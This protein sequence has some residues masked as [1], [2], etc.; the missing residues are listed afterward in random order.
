MPERPWCQ[1]NRYKEGAYPVLAEMNVMNLKG[2]LTPLQ[3]AFFA[4]HRV[5][6]MKSADFFYNGRL[7]GPVDFAHVVVA[8]LAGHRNRVEAAQAASH[9]LARRMGGLGGDID[10]WMRHGLGTGAM[11]ETGGGAANDN[12]SD[13]AAAARL[14]RFRVVL[15]NTT[16][17]GNIG[18]VARAMKNMCLDSLWLVAPKH[19]PSADATARA[20]GAD[21]LLERARVCADLDQALA[22]A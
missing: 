16:H 13:G 3:A 20:S 15:I 5:V 4:E 1:F 12:R 21:G 19:F 18:A 9:D 10:G 11:T 6:G 17:P 2:Q 7:A 8:R 22:A 14:A